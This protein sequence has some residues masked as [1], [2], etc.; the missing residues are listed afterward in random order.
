MVV[1]DQLCPDFDGVS[2]SADDD[3]KNDDHVSDNSGDFRVPLHESQR[4]SGDGAAL[5]R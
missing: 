1:T 3:D 4:R 2:A 5:V